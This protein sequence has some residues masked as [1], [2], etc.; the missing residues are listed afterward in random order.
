M[1][2]P[3]SPAGWPA[4]GLIVL[5]DAV[6]RARLAGLLLG[7]TAERILRRLTCSVRAVK[8]AAVARACATSDARA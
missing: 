6:A 3:F 1:S 8:S 7:N 2:G 5:G 4:L